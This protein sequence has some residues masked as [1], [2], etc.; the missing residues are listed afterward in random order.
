[1]KIKTYLVF[2]FI[3]LILVTFYQSLNAIVTHLNYGKDSEGIAFLAYLMIIIVIFSLIILA[4]ELFNHRSLPPIIISALV[5]SITSIIL[6]AISGYYSVYRLPFRF[7]MMIYWSSTFV[8][9]YY[10]SRQLISLKKV[11]WIIAYSL[12]VFFIAFIIVV[13]Q[14]IDSAS[15]LLLNN[16]YYIF[17]LLPFILSLRP[18]LIRSI[19]VLIIF[20]AIVISLKRTALLSISISLIFIYFYKLTDFNRIIFRKV[21]SI[22][23]FF[24]VI[25][26]GYLIFND[27]TQSYHLSWYERLVSISTDNGSNRLLIWEKIITVLKNQEL[28]YWLI[29][30][31]Y[32]ASE[33]FG[34]AH[35]DFLEILYDFGLVGLLL[36]LIFITKLIH[37]YFKMKKA[38]Y[39]LSP[40]Y[41]V[42]IIMFLMSSMLSQ[43]II[44]P[45]WF[46]LLVVYWGLI[47][48]N[49]EKTIN[50]KQK[51]RPYIGYNDRKLN[52]N[53]LGN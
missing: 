23:I 7:I 17:F 44:Y 53:Y 3:F 52:E 22:F 10:F 11:L 21:I 25:F 14:N 27:L 49:F 26:A 4:N 19:G 42:S 50:K 12:P 39:F 20:A 5:F 2:N 30:R 18:Q 6:T 35:N 40:A 43:L 15:I 33:V 37:Y 46:I 36:Y 16:V 8:I 32:L 48:P 9:T 45:Y 29:G 28:Y 1:M 38:H 51:P 47:I 13:N 31:G 41:G 34:A 24:M